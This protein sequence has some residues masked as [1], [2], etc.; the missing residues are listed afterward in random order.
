MLTRQSAQSNARKRLSQRCAARIL[1]VSFEHLN[2]VLRGHRAS[3]SLLARYEALQVE[4][5][6]RMANQANPRFS[7][8][9]APATRQATGPASATASSPRSADGA[10]NN[11]CPEW[12]ELVGRL[13]FCVC[14]VSVPHSD[15][16]FKQQ[17]FE[18][19]VGADL[20]EANLGQFDS[21]IWENPRLHFFLLHTK[22]LRMALELIQS[23]LAALD[24]LTGCKIGCLDT[25]GKI[26]RTVYPAVEALPAPCP[27]PDTGP[28]PAIPGSDAPDPTEPAAGA[29][30]PAQIAPPAPES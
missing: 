4:E 6:K 7:Q 28:A 22:A 1:G 19:N 21:V 25:A 29:I 11:L 10:S 13:G 27:A 24:L 3:R 5:A 9:L 2:R 15:R 8:D 12:G 20:V 30:M 14:V 17:G 16:L 26:W 18:E 23:R